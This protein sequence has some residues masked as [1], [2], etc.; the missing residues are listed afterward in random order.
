LGVLEAAILKGLK[1]V[2]DKVAAALSEKLDITQFSEF[3]VQVRAILADLED[4][5]RDWSP[6]AR[7]MKAPLD[8][9]GAQGATSCLCC[10]ARVRSVRDL[11]GMGFGASDRVLCP[12]RLPLSDPLLPA[13]NRNP[14]VAAYNS[15]KALS[16]K[17][18]TAAML[19]RSM[20]SGIPGVGGGGGYGALEPGPLSAAAVGAVTGLQMGGGGGMPLISSNVL[21]DASTL[22]LSPGAM[23]QA[24]VGVGRA[25]E[26]DTIAGNLAAGRLPDTRNPGRV[27]GK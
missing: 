15:A 25:V 16:R 19:A 5:L 22:Q 1:A 21:V 13:I 11:Q 17:K 7:G 10:D 23:K 2:S 6:A 4:R 27:P 9:S 8:G 12:E 14:D 18:E 3:K 24:G 26:V 20:S